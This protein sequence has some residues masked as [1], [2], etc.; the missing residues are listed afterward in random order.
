[1][2]L[3][4]DL[5]TLAN[6][7]QILSLLVAVLALIA[8]LLPWI[9]PNPSSFIQTLRQKRLIL[10]YTLV[11]ALFFLLGTRICILD[12]CSGVSATINE[13]T[14]EELVGSKVYINGV[15]T[16]HEI[17]QHVFIIARDRD[18]Q[19]WLIAD[20]VQVNAAGYWA[21]IARLDD[22]AKINGEVE[23]TARVT[24]RPTDYRVGQIV[25]TP[26]GKGISSN[27]SVYVRRIR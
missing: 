4:L 11:S 15:S 6:W 10:F 27:K 12:G 7:A 26:P 2:N 17:C 16:V 25:S 18:S 23:I 9:W 8:S 13:P 24:A 21:G 3:S 22:I 20:L 19:S 5:P 14:D 1:M